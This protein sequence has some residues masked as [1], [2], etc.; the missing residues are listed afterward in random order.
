MTTLI[1]MPV[2]DRLQDVDLFDDPSWG[3]EEDKAYERLGIS[4]FSPL[5]ETAVALAAIGLFVLS[6]ALIVLFV[7]AGHY[8]F[9][10]LFDGFTLPR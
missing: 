9:D 4:G 3:S 1:A 5:T 8:W 10:H 7:R 6:V 2:A